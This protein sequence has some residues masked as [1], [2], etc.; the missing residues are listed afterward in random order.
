MELVQD[1]ASKIATMEWE[2]FT[3]TV[4]IGGRAS[5]QDDIRTFLIMRTSQIFIW[6]DEL[7]ESYHSDLQDAKASGRN[8]VAEKYA[9]MMKFTHP[10]EYEAI[11]NKLPVLADE[12]VNLSDEITK[13][14]V[15]WNF[16][17]SKIYPC[18]M[19][20]S[21]PI[22]SQQ[23]NRKFTSY[24]TASSPRIWMNSVSVST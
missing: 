3:T 14:Y 24:E 2:M 23:D 12:I 22:T 9:R 19:T 4:N 10:S 7:L 16:D 18:I 1:L 8:L 11:K 21:R 6:P 15:Q 5:C 13:A 20:R 17:M